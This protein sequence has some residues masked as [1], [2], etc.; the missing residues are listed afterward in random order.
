MNF[1]KKAFLIIFVFFG[2][3]F[4]FSLTFA[5]TCTRYNPTISVSP[6]SQSGAPGQTLTYT[7]QVTSNDSSACSPRTYYFTVSNC[8]SGWT[9]S[10]SLTSA[11]LSP[12]QTQTITISI[13]SSPTASLLFYT[14]FF[15]VG[16]IPGLNDL[17][18]TSF[19]YL[20][21][22]PCI[23]STPT[24]SVSP[25]SQSGT[26]GQTLT[27]TAIVTSN[28][29]SGCSARTYY[30]SISNCPS[31]WT[32]SRSPTSATLSPGQTQ[33]VNIS[34][35][36]SPTASPA[37]YIFRF[38]VGS[39]P[40]RDDLGYISFTYRVITPTTPIP[41]PTPPP[42]PA[43]TCIRSNPTISVSPSSQSGV[44]GQTLTYTAQ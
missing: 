37:S 28:D 5:Q 35:T 6:S 29:F 13:T 9:C 2:L 4:L 20:I 18:Y 8:P 1:Q 26:P 25:S 14:L 15:D 24:I 40:D 33:T 17:G 27:Y 12:G 11:T 31:G 19:T 16:S 42:T 23:P 7:A 44:P 22:P 38:K 30:F 10:L 34:I 39:T 21:L 36:S 41:T 43:P 32:C 3:F